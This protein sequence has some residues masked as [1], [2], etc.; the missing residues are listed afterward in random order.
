VGELSAPPDTQTAIWE[1]ISKGRGGGEKRE[2]P[3]RISD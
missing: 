3:T 2:A 1:L